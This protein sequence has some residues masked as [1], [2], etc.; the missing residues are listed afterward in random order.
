M[1]GMISKKSL[2]QVP[3]ETRYQKLRKAWEMLKAGYGVVITEK[4][5]KTSVQ[6]LRQWATE[7]DFP[8]EVR[9]KSI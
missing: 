2:A 5:L 4:R 7:L 6:T 8:L 1:L 9:K 3:L